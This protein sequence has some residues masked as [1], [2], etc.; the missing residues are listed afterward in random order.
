MPD[1]GKAVCGWAQASIKHCDTN[2]DLPM[3]VVTGGTFPRNGV[4]VFMHQ[5]FRYTGSF[6]SVT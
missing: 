6:Q 5:A 1:S 4:H 2:I 3:P